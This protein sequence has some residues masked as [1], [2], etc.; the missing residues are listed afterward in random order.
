MVTMFEAVKIGCVP[1]IEGRASIAVSFS[2]RDS[3]AAIRRAKRLGMTVA[4]LRVDLFSS[5]KE[6]HVLSVIRK[7]KGVPLIATIRSRKEGGKWKGREAERL[8]LFMAVMPRVDA[9]DIEWTSQSIRGEVVREAKRLKKTVIVS[10]HDFKKTPSAVFLN[11]IL[12]NAK[13]SGADV[14]KIAV[15]ARSQKDVRLLAEFTCS[16]ASEG[17]ITL[18]MGNQGALSRVLFPSLGSLLTF[19]H[20]GRPT[21]PGQ[22]DLETMA[23]YLKKL[24]TN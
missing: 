21:A 2:D 5:Q 7:F 12:K 22:M 18:S 13:L 11:T 9:V 16:H 4:E 8:K 14:V 10:Y 20:I 17:L 3:L 19:A 6:E 23:G 24:I 15:M 1:I